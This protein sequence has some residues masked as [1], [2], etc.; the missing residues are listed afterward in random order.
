MSGRGILNLNWAWT[1][2]QAFAAQGGAHVV[3]S[4]GSR[5]TPLALAAH[6]HPSLITHM[7]VDERSAGFFALGLARR[8]EA[9]VALVCT[10]GTAAANYHPALAEAETWGIPL[11]AFTADRPPRLRGVGA[12]Q[13]INQ[14]HLFGPA[15]KAME[16]PVPEPAALKQ[17][18][19]RVALALREACATPQAPLH[20]NVPFD[21]PLAPE[22]EELAVWQ[23]PEQ[24]V[25][26]L[27]DTVLRVEADAVSQLGWQLSQA[28]RPLVVAGPGAGDRLA[29]RAILQW[30]AQAGVPVLADVGSGLRGLATDALVLH[31]ADLY[32]RP[33]LSE[34][35]VPDLVITVGRMMTSKAIATWLAN[36]AAPVVG[37]W[38]DWR[39]RDP[40]A[41]VSTVLAGNVG[42]T[43]GQ[44]LGAPLPAMDPEW[45]AAWRTAE[46]RVRAALQ[47]VE[48]VIPPEAAA[49]RA[50]VAALP[51][52]AGLV[53]SNSLPV[54]HADSYAGAF[55]ADVACLTIRGANGIDGLT[56]IAFGAARGAQR[57]TLLVTGDLAFLHDVGALVLARD[58]TVPVVIL[59]LDNC[60]GG[61]FHHLPV[62]T[63]VPEF[64]TLFGTP[65]R[66]D[67]AQIARGFGLAVK[68]VDSAPAVGF[69]VG[70]ALSEP[71]VTVVIFSASR[72][73]TVAA[74]RAFV[75]AIAQAG[76]A[77][78]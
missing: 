67:L 58:C 10:S 56:S 16:L 19:L 77:D 37:V 49:V 65:H 60:G 1:L 9:P 51:A 52:E 34:T 68:R 42:D 64:E 5:S 59:V 50:A 23:P 36:Q 22:A 54:R 18:A 69:A 72:D 17:M 76:G 31:H 53:L 3:V 21:E 78:A 20:I 73:Q 45:P 26:R 11:I 48:P 38:P 25:P 63:A 71:G 40:D 33:P 12:A 32:L 2:M 39:G 57:P 28:A 29:A 61:I 15:V 75:A 66:Q 55:P 70:E 6:R 46:G 7:V 43:F 44:L 62:A 30:A 24:P 8:T 27:A 74:H 35:F 13:T 41:T 14:V 4:P 47:R